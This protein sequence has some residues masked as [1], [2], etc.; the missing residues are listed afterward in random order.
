VMSHR[1][2]WL[3][4]SSIYLPFLVRPLARSKF[5]SENAKFF[6]PILTKPEVGRDQS[7]SEDWSRETLLE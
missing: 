1:D 3:W 2:R 7:T 4:L 5:R 6:Q